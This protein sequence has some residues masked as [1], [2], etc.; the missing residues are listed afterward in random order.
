MHTHTRRGLRAALFRRARNNAF[1]EV[2]LGTQHT[3]GPRV[4]REVAARWEH[5]H[6]VG[7]VVM[8]GGRPHMCSCK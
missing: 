7:K 3:V 1:D 8:L 5:K 4:A 6:F 2:G